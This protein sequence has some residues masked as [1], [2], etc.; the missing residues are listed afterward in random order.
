MSTGGVEGPK[1]QFIVVVSTAE[2]T[3]TTNALGQQSAGSA[4]IGQHRAAVGER[5]VAGIGYCSAVHT[6]G[7]DAVSHESADATATSH[8]LCKHTGRG[9]PAGANTGAVGER[10]VAGIEEIADA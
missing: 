8:A 5:H 6:H 1:E 7:D 4:P 3:T 10:H 9:R 2:S